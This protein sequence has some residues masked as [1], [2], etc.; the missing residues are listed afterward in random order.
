VRPGHLIV[1]VV[2]LGLLFDA[3]LIVVAGRPAGHPRDEPAPPAAPAPA[4][5]PRHAA[6]GVLVTLDRPSAAEIRV[7]TRWGVSSQTENLVELDTFDGCGTASVLGL[8]F[9]GGDQDRMRRAVT[10]L[11][12]ITGSTF[13]LALMQRS[14]RRLQTDTPPRRAVAYAAYDPENEQAV[15]TARLTGTRVVTVLVVHVMTTRRRGCSAVARRTSA[16]ALLRNALSPRLV[17]G[18]FD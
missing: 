18:R 4:P 14:K 6:G 3:A 13:N 7:P 8:S 11:G 1:P 10:I 16:M 5:A 9:R 12:Q 17:G 2:A 15:M